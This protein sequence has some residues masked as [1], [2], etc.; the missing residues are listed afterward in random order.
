MNN[1]SFQDYYNSLF[2]TL[3]LKEPQTFFM[4]AVCRNIEEGTDYRRCTGKTT[5][6]LVRAMADLLYRNSGTTIVSISPPY[7]KSI[8]IEPWA[9]RLGLA[10]AGGSQ[11]WARTDMVSDARIKFKHISSLSAVPT[12]AVYDL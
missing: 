12:D 1:F 3:G 11:S 8:M 5:E 2:R 10:R 4:E 9:T 7:S 6:I